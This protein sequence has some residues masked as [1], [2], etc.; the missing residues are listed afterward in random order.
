MKKKIIIIG[1]GIAGL[2]L[3]NLFKR[4]SEYEYIIYEKE[5]SLNLEEGYGIQLSVNSVSIINKLGFNKL[6]NTDKYNPS[7]LD[8]YTASK[9]KICDLDLTKFN[10]DINKYTTLKR[11]IL[12]KFLREELFSN[13]IKF[14]KILNDI[15]K[16]DKKI[17]VTFKDGTSDEADYIVVSDGVFSSSKNIIEKTEKTPNYYGSIAIRTKVSNELTSSFNSKNISVIMCPNA[18]IVLYPVNQLK[19]MNLVC[20]IKKKL[21]NQIPLKLILDKIILNKYPALSNLFKGNLKSWPIYTSN[22]P[23]KSK[24]K[25]IFYI[26]D[27][28]YTFPPSMAQGASQSIESAK[29]LFELIIEEKENI[30]DR[31]FNNRIARIKQIK[32]RSSFNYFTFQLSNPLFIFLRNL[33]IKFALKNKTFCEFY[34]GRVFRK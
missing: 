20:I 11:S 15:E 10:N 27:S 13:S 34:L 4:C 9:N 1:S 7:S 5:D 26:G 18:H 21:D 22:A 6:N 17:K 16:V 30:Q 28:F 19:E 2:T 23:I 24:Y 3:A 25:N 31:Y 32:N 12:I 8:F 29:E 33:I 14:G